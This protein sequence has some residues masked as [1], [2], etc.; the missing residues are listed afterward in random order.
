[1]VLP[2]RVGGNLERGHGTIQFFPQQKKGFV[3]FVGLSFV[4]FVGF[5]GFILFPF[6][7]V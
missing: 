4:G 1:L 5:F 7:R 2:I 6:L 3:G